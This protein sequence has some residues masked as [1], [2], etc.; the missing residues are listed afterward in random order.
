M[1]V[2][3]DAL[4]GQQAELELRS[5]QHVHVLVCYHLPHLSPAI[6]RACLFA[7]QSPRKEPGGKGRKIN[8]GLFRAFTWIK[9]ECASALLNAIYLI[10]PM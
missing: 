5:A 8:V 3:D 2:R 9:K 4:R 1:V 7:V 10:S 6:V